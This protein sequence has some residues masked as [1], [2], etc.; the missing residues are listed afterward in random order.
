[1]KDLF[2]FLEEME[3]GN[4]EE[5]KLIPLEG[6]HEEKNIEEP[7]NTEQVTETESEQ[8]N[9][10]TATQELFDVSSEEAELARKEKELSEHAAKAKTVEKA[11]G[12][13]T[14]TKVGVKD[15]FE[16]TISTL[17]RYYGESIPITIYC[18][19]AE[20]ENKKITLNILRTRMETDYPE[21]VANHTEMLF[22]KKNEQTYVVPT[23]MAKK[24][25]S[26]SNT[27]IRKKRPLIPH[28]VL[29]QF[30]AV[31]QL[32]AKEELEIHGDIYE[33]TN[34][35]KVFID[36]PEQDVHKFYCETTESAISIISRIGMDCK[37]LAEIHSHHTLNPIPSSIDNSAERIPN[38]LYIIV[39][40]IDHFYPN[41]FC[42]MFVDE[43]TG[44]IPFDTFEIF[45]RPVYALPSFDMERIHI[46][47]GE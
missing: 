37:K 17:I 40:N 9:K 35:G 7:V 33:C 46:R 8:S 45:K 44:W 14:S 16:P 34:T 2:D 13:K 47:K 25:G 11:T 24:K 12:K 6:T 21:L 4:N 29:G 15:T 30:I 5:K 3:A 27:L 42:R 22:I 36:I 1:M 38:M 10:V 43:S 41:I 20:I 28:E 39:G 26:K 23:L 32:F 31:A 18:T 19:E